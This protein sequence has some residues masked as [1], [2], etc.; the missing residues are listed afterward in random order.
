MH[1]YTH[2][3]YRLF[4]GLCLL[5]I[6]GMMAFPMF[7]F[8]Q[9]TATPI[10]EGTPIEISGV[11]SE[12]NATTIVVAG[13]TVDISG[14]SFDSTITTGSTVSVAGYLQPTNIIL[15][16]SITV[17][18]III[19]GTSVTVTPTPSTST[20]T[21]EATPETTPDVTLTPTVAPNLIVVVEGPVINIINNIITIYDFDIEVE[22]QHPILSIIN[23]GDIV[24]VEGSF[25]STGVIVA[26]VVSNI[27]TVTTVSSGSTATV[28]LEGP[29]ESINGNIVTIN[30]VAVQL[31]ANDPLLST[32]QVGS[33]LSV[34]GNFQGSG[35][36][37][38]L[39]VVNVTVVNNVVIDG[40]PFCWYH[41]DGMG[42]GMGM[43]HWHCDGMGMGMGDGMGM[44]MGR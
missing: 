26:N 30:G 8:A 14:L 3:N 35:S 4:V 23:I 32:L 40:N 18:T 7:T 25:G 33:F 29:V 1:S 42:M 37:I 31:P 12:V 39:V 17:I 22:P 9:D 41:E 24:H 2:S 19:D 44:G 34:Q 16:D 13:L 11:V 27:S 28:G 10:P 38:I 6:A 5:I 43:G 21:P 36:N 20:P 15:A